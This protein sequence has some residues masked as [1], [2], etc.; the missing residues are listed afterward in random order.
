MKA[1]SHILQSLGFI[2][3]ETRTYLASLEYGSGSVIHIAALT[4]LSRQA[5]YLAIESLMERGLM[6]SIPQGKKKYFIAEPPD[7]LLAYAKRSEADM[8]EKISD[9]QRAIP[10]LQLRSGGEKPVVKLF[11]GKEGVKTI[12]TDINASPE[13]VIHEITDLDAAHASI[14][15]KEFFP[16]RLALKKSGKF[17]KA[18][19]AGEPT[20]KTVDSDRYFLPKELSG[21][22]SNMTLYGDK[23]AFVAFEGRVYAV[24]IEDKR[25]A[26]MMNILFELAFETVSKRYSQ[27]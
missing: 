26:R 22:K 8:K 24:L 27:N 9:L 2:D 14:S 3:S 13:T 6:S 25:L 15:P 5:T 23:I 11:E 12:L 18:I 4:G 1:I 21:F 16:K 20:V 10:E 17:L 7:K 19:C